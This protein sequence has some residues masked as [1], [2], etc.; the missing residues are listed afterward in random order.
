MECEEPGTEL[1]YPGPTSVAGGTSGKATE[2]DGGGTTELRLGP[3]FDRGDTPEMVACLL[4]GVA[5]EVEVGVPEEICLPL[6]KIIP[7]EVEDGWVAWR[8]ACLPPV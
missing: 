5:R 2:K 4:A 6:L 3:L 1:E 7:S 8:L